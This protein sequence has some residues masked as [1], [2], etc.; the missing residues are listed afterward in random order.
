MAPRIEGGE[1]KPP[2]WNKLR[3][4]VNKR[5][6]HL[7]PFSSAV[8]TARWGNLGPLN[9]YLTL[10][11]G[12]ANDEE[13]ASPLAALMILE[14]VFGGGGRSKELVEKWLIRTNNPKDPYYGKEADEN[15][16]GEIRPGMLP[17]TLRAIR[18][19]IL[20]TNLFLE[21]PRN[22]IAFFRGTTQEPLAE[23]LKKERWAAFWASEAFALLA[24]AIVA[25]LVH[26]RVQDISPVDIRNTLVSVLTVIGALNGAII[27]GAFSKNLKD[28][29]VGTFIGG[30][31][32]LFIGYVAPPDSLIFYPQSVALP[33]AALSGGA[34][35]F[36]LNYLIHRLF[37]ITQPGREVPK[38]KIKEAEERFAKG[39]RVKIPRQPRVIELKN[40]VL[41]RIQEIYKQVKY[42]FPPMVGVW[43]ERQIAQGKH[44]KIDS[45]LPIFLDY[46][47]K[48]APGSGVWNEI[49][50]DRLSKANFAPGNELAEDLKKAI[51]AV[52]TLSDLLLRLAQIHVLRRGVTLPTPGALPNFFKTYGKERLEVVKSF[53]SS[54]PTLAFSLALP[55]LPRVHP[56][57]AALSLWDY[58]KILKQYFDAAT[59]G[60][61]GENSGN[62][63]ELPRL[64]AE[65]LQGFVERI[66]SD[67]YLIEP[68]LKDPLVTRQIPNQQQVKPVELVELV[69]LE[70]PVTEA[71]N[72]PLMVEALE[73]LAMFYHEGGGEE[74]AAGAI[75]HTLSAMTK[76]IVEGQVKGQGSP[77]MIGGIIS[78]I[79]FYI[80]A[81]EFYKLVYPTQMDLFDRSIANLT[82]LRDELIRLVINDF[83]ADPSRFITE[84]DYE[85][86][87]KINLVIQLM[88]QESPRETMNALAHHIESLYSGSGEETEKNMK[89]RATTILL[90]KIYSSAS[91]L[92]PDIANSLF[93][94]I[95]PAKKPLI[96]MLIDLIR[97]DINTSVGRGIDTDRFSDESYRRGLNHLL[98]TLFNF[99]FEMGT[100]GE[101]GSILAEL[102]TR[103]EDYNIVAPQ[104]AYVK[105][106]EPPPIRVFV[107]E[108][109]NT[110]NEAL[111]WGL[112]KINERT[113]AGEFSSEEGEMIK[114]LINQIKTKISELLNKLY[115][116]DKG[117]TEA[118]SA[119][120]WPGKG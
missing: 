108:I 51:R 79:N 66:E 77:L 116:L 97:N 109:I 107:Q 16:Q 69:E 96:A 115:Y 37:P 12:L 56:P 20:D 44:F 9:R 58:S 98:E 87:K 35:F 4:E 19:L 30:F 89:S 54:D 22:L 95:F 61:N 31:L 60:Q 3:R 1:P 71:M 64:Q 21:S 29:G 18:E 90:Y 73:V 33:A 117:L 45:I 120:S 6:L 118:S 88:L 10:I 25:L 86:A 48:Q 26:N 65:W 103:I 28:V 55:V 23:F 75:K 105:T 2:L 80:K 112:N 34:T 52:P 42:L 5:K 76:L 83:F 11:E 53:S 59:Y 38:E 93:N 27:G 57:L 114:G 70:K 72:P 41:S 74:G 14:E 17:K 92:N 84:T 46:W 111:T 43:G 78:A 67:S 104:L 102:V 39:E 47:R 81:G 36:G 113:Q 7:D 100:P 68:F 40:E 110:L 62:S 101:I 91:K 8:D 63:G 15:Y 94:I 85:K 50:L 119:F 32:G 106:R 24:T 99:I 13:F 82:S 49:L